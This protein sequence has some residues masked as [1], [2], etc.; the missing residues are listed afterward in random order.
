MQKFRMRNLEYFLLSISSLVIY[1]Y[2]Q[3]EI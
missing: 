3:G 1:R 2:E